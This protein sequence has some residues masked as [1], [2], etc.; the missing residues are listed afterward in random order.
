MPKSL[1]RN[2]H[3]DSIAVR[4]AATILATALLASAQTITGVVSG[5]IVDTSG[6]AVPGASVTLLHTATSLRT[7]TSSE[8]SGEFVFPSVQPGTYSL[9][10]EAKGFKRFEKTPV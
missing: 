5:A 9:I 10:V 6:L 4:L 8:A 2:S 7:A 1:I 3:A